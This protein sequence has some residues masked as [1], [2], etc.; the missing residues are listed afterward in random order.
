ML[1]RRRVFRFV[2]PQNVVSLFSV[3][4]LK[5]LVSGNAKNAFFFHHPILLC[6]L[7]SLFFS[8]YTFHSLILHVIPASYLSFNHR[9]RKSCYTF[10][11]GY[12]QFNCFFVII[13]LRATRFNTKK[14][15]VL[16]KSVFMYFVW[17]S[18][19]PDRPWGPLILLYNGYRVSFPG[20]KRPGRDVEHPLPTSVVVIRE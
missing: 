3:C 13:H 18:K 5:F 1:T 11:N 9:A 10:E 7:L 8:S 4:V 6:F 16:L 20:V 17:I 14:S 19:S 15:Y 12:K 2:W